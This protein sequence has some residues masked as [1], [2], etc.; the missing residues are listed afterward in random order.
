MLSSRQ[1]EIWDF[2]EIKSRAL[3]DLYLA[4]V[5]MISDRGYTNHAKVRLVY[6][7]CRE[8]FNRLPEVISGDSFEKA[9]QYK[10]EA[11]KLATAWNK[12]EELF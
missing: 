4:A 3:G 10:N 9:V 11:D 8:I 1:K 12:E 7:A 6:H 2:L 5:K